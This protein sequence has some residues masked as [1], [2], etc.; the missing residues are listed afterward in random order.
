LIKANLKPEWIEKRKTYVTPALGVRVRCFGQ[1][2][3]AYIAFLRQQYYSP[4]FAVFTLVLVLWIGR[5]GFFGLH[6]VIPAAVALAWLYVRL[7]RPDLA[8][9][10]EGRELAHGLSQYIRAHVGGIQAPVRTRAIALYYPSVAFCYFLLAGTA[11]YTLWQ[12]LKGF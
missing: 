10:R 4:I 9:Y 1:K 6:Y 7:T 5:F 3:H 8:R 2:Y 11:F 12:L